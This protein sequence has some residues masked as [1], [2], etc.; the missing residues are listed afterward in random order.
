MAEKEQV[1]KEKITYSGVF[2]FKGFYACAHKWLQNESYGLTEDKYSEKVAGNAK[3][4]VIEW[5]ASKKLSDYF[6]IEIKVKFDIAELSEVEL[7]IDGKKKKAN[8]GKVDVDIKGNLIRDPDSKW[9]ETPVWR[10]LRDTYNKYVIP[11]RAE[12]IGDKVDGSVK[13]F[14]EELKAY[15]D[16]LGKR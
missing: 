10:F 14:K 9:E 11:K 1:V 12:D 15:L 7:E 2:D 3:D 8:K 5:T 4:I 6:K 13:D 16:L